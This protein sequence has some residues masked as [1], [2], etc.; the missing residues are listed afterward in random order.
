MKQ[1]RISLLQ[2]R[3]LLFSRYGQRCWFF[4]LQKISSEGDICK[5]HMQQQACLHHIQGFVRCTSLV[6]PGFPDWHQAKITWI[7]KSFFIDLGDDI[8]TILAQST[9]LV[10]YRFTKLIYSSCHIFKFCGQFQISSLCQGQSF[11][12]VFCCLLF[13]LER[14]L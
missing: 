4:R 10:D 9:R 8:V 1:E 12:Q 13:R 6:L 5:W 14:S 2:W 3:R 7:N 11:S